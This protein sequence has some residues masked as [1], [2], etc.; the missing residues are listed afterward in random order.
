MYEKDIRIEINNI[1]NVQRAVYR[2]LRKRMGLR[3]DEA[4][5]VMLGYIMAEEASR[6]PFLNL[7]N[8][9]ESIYRRA[10]VYTNSDLDKLVHEWQH[11]VS[12]YAEALNTNQIRVSEE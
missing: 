12:N 2:S 7:I 4:N 6:I 5:F 1:T 11:L 8:L 9:A 3:R 10:G